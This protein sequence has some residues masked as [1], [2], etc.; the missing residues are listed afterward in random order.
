MTCRQGLRPR[1]SQLGHRVQSA[2]DVVVVQQPL[3]PTPT[4]TNTP[5]VD[6]NV[7]IDTP[8]GINVGID[9]TR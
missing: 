8:I 9:S 2:F 1:F 4:N 7:D 3:P 6:I 5:N